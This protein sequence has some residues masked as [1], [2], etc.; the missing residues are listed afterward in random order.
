MIKAVIFDFD[1]L[2]F[3]T[4][5][6][7][8]CVFQKYNKKFNINLTE[9]TRASFIG[10]NENLVRQELRAAYPTL[11]VDKYRDAQ[12]EEVNKII[13]SG[14][15]KAKKGL[16]ELLNYLQNHN[17]KKAIISG[18]SLAKMSFLFEKNNIDAGLFNPIV[19][20][21]SN[22]ESKPSPQPFLYC[23]KQMGVKPS[24]CVML[25]DGYNGIRG[26]YAAGCKSI[27]IPDTVP[28][29]DEIRKKATVLADLTQVITYL[30]N[31]N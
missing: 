19:S 28:A 14:K 3:D 22:M 30:Q 6:L 12:L 29:T 26:A 20:R 18:N 15:P 25:E 31:Q 27:F 4:E 1:G 5:I 8:K 23:A 13:L 2:M 17:Y 24:E 16:F 9:K 10:K 21:D 11:D 7:W